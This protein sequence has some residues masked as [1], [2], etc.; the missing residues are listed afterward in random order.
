MAY[1]IRNAAKDDDCTF[2]VLLTENDSNSQQNAGSCGGGSNFAN[3]CDSRENFTALII[4][5]HCSAS[6]ML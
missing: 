3:P 5:M 6:L 1:F 2:F 4:N